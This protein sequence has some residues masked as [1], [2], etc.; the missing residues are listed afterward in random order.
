MMLRNNFCAPSKH[1]GELEGPAAGRF[2]VVS[3]TKEAVSMAVN[4]TGT[5]DRTLSSDT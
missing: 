1:G 5:P 2:A 4:C 3:P